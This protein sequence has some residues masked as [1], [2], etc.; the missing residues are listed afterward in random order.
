MRIIPTNKFL[1][2]CHIEDSA[3][4]DFCSVNIQTLNHL[5][6]ECTQVQYF[7]AENSDFLNDY[8]IDSRFSL[9]TTSLMN[10]PATQIKNF[11]ILLGKYFIFKNKCL[12]TLP[13]FL[14]FQSYLNPKDLTLKKK[15]ILYETKLPILKRNGGNLML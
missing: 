14:H 3:L 12:K 2:K 6:W 11:I 10:R 7:W 4:C 9:K 1:L 13:I 15:Y 5:V 8:N